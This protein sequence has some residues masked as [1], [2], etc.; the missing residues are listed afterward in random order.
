[1]EGCDPAL[2]RQLHQGRNVLTE[3]GAVAVD[4]KW[5]SA[6]SD[7]VVSWETHK[8]SECVPTVVPKLAAA[9]PSS[10]SR[11]HSAETSRFRMH[12]LTPAGE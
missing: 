2:R 10:F 5:V 9:P 4:T 1:M 8:K 12:G 11:A 6:A 3:D 7:A